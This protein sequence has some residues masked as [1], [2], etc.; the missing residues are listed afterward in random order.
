MEIQVQ[1]EGARTLLSFECATAVALGDTVV[2][3]EGV[4][5]GISG[6][7]VA[8]KRGSYLGPLCRC[9][10][11]GFPGFKG[12]V[13]AQAVDSAVQDRIVKSRLNWSEVVDRQKAERDR[14]KL[15]KSAAAT[16][17][18]RA[19][20]IRCAQCEELFDKNQIYD[21]HLCFDCFDSWGPDTGP[22]YYDEVGDPPYYPA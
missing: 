3:A 4:R 5:R 2:I 10:P 11:V 16:P 9:V 1:F 21:H 7:V 20:R 12:P 15:E 18:K 6:L 19:R 8:L 22:P 13:T 14:Q 17:N